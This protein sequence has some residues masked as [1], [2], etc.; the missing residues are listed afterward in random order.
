MSLSYKDEMRLTHWVLNSL[1]LRLTGKR[2]SILPPAGVESDE[3]PAHTC[4]IGSLASAPDLTYH[5]PQP[6]SAMGMVLMVEPGAGHQVRLVLRGQFDVSHRYLPTLAVMERELN[7]VDGRPK[8]SQKLPEGFKMFTVSFND[9]ELNLNAN[10]LNVWQE[11]S[12]IPLIKAQAAVWAEDPRMFRRCSLNERG[13]ANLIFPWQ[14]GICETD[15]DLAAHLARHLFEGRDILQHDVRLRARLRVSPPSFVD[16]P[17]RFL[18]EVYLQNATS[19]LEG[20]SHGL[21]RPF[22]TDTYFEF[23]LVEGTQHPVPHRLQP[24]DYRYEPEDGVAGYGITCAVEQLASATFGT[25]SMPTFAQSR[26]DAPSAQEVGMPVAPR[27]HELA[28]D[29][30]SVLD[31]FVEALTHYGK[32]WDHVEAQLRGEGRAAELLAL[33][34]DRQEYEAEVRRIEQGLGLLKA[35]PELMQCF[36]WMNEVMGQAIKL[37]KKSFDGWHLFQLGFVLTQVRAVYERHAQPDDGLAASDF[38]DVLWFAT[39]GGKTEA[40][41]GIIAFAMLYSRMQGRAFGTT[42]WM[43][44]PLRMLSVQQFQRLSYV[45]AQAEMLRV[46]V[47]LEGHPFTVGY[48]TGSGTPS[49]VSRPDGSGAAVWL[50]DLSEE[51]LKGFQFI[52]D[53]PFCGLVNSIEMER[54]YSRARLMHHCR[55]PECWTNASAG[56]GRHGEGIRE[57]IGIYVSDEECYRYLPTVLVGTVDKLA[58]IAHNERFAGFFGAHRYFCPEHGFNQ[59]AKCR[60]RRIKMGIRDEYESFECGNNSRTSAIRTV[61]LSPMSDPGFSFLIQDEL[62]LLRESLGNFDA[63]YETLLQGLQSAHG[64]FPAKILAATATIK[65]FQSHLHNLYLKHG[66]RFPAPGATRG[67]SFYARIAKDQDGPL[68]RRWFAG[69]LPL[70]YSRGEAERATAE[71]ATRFLDL[72]D[73]MR[74]ELAR[75]HLP[76]EE[77]FGFP[78]ARSEQ[79]LAYIGKYLNTDLVFANQKRQITSIVEHLENLHGRRTVERHHKLLDGQT[80]L[81]AILAAIRIVETKGPDDP[82]RHLIATSVVSHGVDIAELNFMVLDGWPRSTADYIQSSARSGRVH[83]GIIISV[84]NSAKLFEA[85]VFLNFGDYHFFLEK[86]VDSVP[87]NR[88]APHILQRTLPGVFAAVILNWAKHQPGWGA[89]LDRSARKLSEALAAEDGAARAAI[90]ATVLS[91]LSVPSSLKGVFDRRVLAE[92]QKKL[93][94]EVDRALHRLQNL[95]ASQTEADVGAALESIFQFGPMRS[96]RDIENQIAVLPAGPRESEV[97][98]A[99]GK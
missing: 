91:T 84:L 45:V 6:P 92:F 37:Q 46:R 72:I 2:D 44:F 16:M 33:Q 62:H 58:V 54:D 39:G 59:N 15:D 14:E 60:H 23:D 86:L 57:E 5:G 24:E 41:L 83:P 78:A 68:I 93:E 89:Q 3:D 31:G 17:S 42:A 96:F 87:I 34:A 47:G 21:R 30:L 27:F 36:A 81:E 75:E 38:V 28:N 82:M 95:S 63:H 51:Q 98:A 64:G 74:A 56:T 69:I 43:R 70:G 25:N 10:A 55:N 79:L 90:R 49:N 80:P 97:L 73:A 40:Y 99:L 77:V 11:V 85:G 29:P 53:C 48:F 1:R 19:P 32:T 76:D 26:L 67:E 61:Q 7:V 8:D 66:V 4:L 65:D 22:L 52:S 94:S 9:I 20:V 35:H 13:M 12:L 88:F 50:P 71:V 18:L